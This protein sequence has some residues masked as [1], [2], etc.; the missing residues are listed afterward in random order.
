MEKQYSDCPLP[1]SDELRERW[2][3]WTQAMELSHA[4]LMSGLQAQVS[5]DGDIHAAYRAWY[6][7][8]QSLK[9][10][11]TIIQEN[12]LKEIDVS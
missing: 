1:T 7:K 9:W 4:M 12:T 11:D 10:K 8:F 3:Q 6:D 5:P 2:A